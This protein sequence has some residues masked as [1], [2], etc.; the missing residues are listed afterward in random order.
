M[1]N[2][3]SNNSLTINELVDIFE[4]ISIRHKQ[5]NDFGFG[6]EFDINQA[7]ELNTPFLW[8]DFGDAGYTTNINDNNN[9]TSI[10]FDFRLIVVDKINNTLNNDNE[11]GD[12]SHNGLEIFSDTSQ[13]LNDIVGEMTTSSFYTTNNINIKE[14]INFN[15]LRNFEDSNLNGWECDLT[16][17]MPFKFTVCG[18]P[19]TGESQITLQSGGVVEVPTY[20]T[21]DSLSSCSTFIGLSQ[22]IDYTVSATYTSPNLTFTR[23]SG[24]TY[25]TQI[26]LTVDT[27]TY[28]T[29]ATNNNGK[30]IFTRNDGNTYSVTESIYDTDNG[31]STVSRKAELGGTLNK[32]TNIDADNNEFSITDLKANGNNVLVTP[33]Y[34]G[35]GITEGYVFLGD[36]SANGLIDIS[37]NNSL[38][39]LDDNTLDVNIGSSGC[40]FDMKNLNG[41]NEVIIFGFGDAINKMVIQRNDNS[42]YQIG[43]TGTS[44]AGI[45]INVN[46]ST[47]SAGIINTTI[48]SATGI[49]A[50]DDYTL[51]T[52]NLEVSGNSLANY[53][54]Q[55]STQPGWNDLSI[56]TKKYVDDTNDYTVSGSFNDSSNIITFT[57]NDSSTYS[58]DITD[59]SFY[60]GLNFEDTE[61]W[62]YR[63]PE[64]FK[65]DTVD[66]PDSITYSLYLEGVTY[67]LGATISTYDS[68]SAS[69]TSVGF[70]KL[71]CTK[72]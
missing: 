69:V 31:L 45:F 5:L 57:K 40:R 44:S 34:T 52:N 35:L 29:G 65:V 48:I 46:S 33:S 64:D 67:S 27:N 49:N 59:N 37:T 54:V 63:A 15:Y 62:N 23:L 25:G 10:D 19:F 1:S 71:N 38:I 70:L 68:F 3:N 36:Y 14:D 42:I 56:P 6:A 55:P 22:S 16:I 7:T 13:I 11:S 41:D 4:D 61:P 66:N 2:I 17:S 32:N 20:L 12:K 72:I 30:L 43:N 9:F 39:D 50:T 47:I 60:I 58:V 51:Y 8:V 21:C 24:A 28:T 26:N 18:S 53:T